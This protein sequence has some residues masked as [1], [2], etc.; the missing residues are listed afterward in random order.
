MRV[1]RIFFALLALTIFAVMLN[2]AYII[3]GVSSWHSGCEEAAVKFGK[4][5]GLEYQTYMQKF[6]NARLM[7]M[8]QQFQMEQ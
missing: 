3:I 1:V 4:D 2:Q 7:Q 6:C 8:Q 5:Y